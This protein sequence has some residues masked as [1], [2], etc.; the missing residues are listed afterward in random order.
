MDAFNHSIIQSIRFSHHKISFSLLF[1]RTFF[2]SNFFTTH[3]H[4]HTFTQN[5]L[6]LP[7]T[8]QRSGL[9]PTTVV[10]IFVCVLSALC[11]LHMSNTIS[12]VPGNYNFTKDVSYV[13]LTTQPK[14]LP[15]DYSTQLTS[16]FFI[17]IISQ[18]QT[19]TIL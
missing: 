2:L 1:F 19:T 16:P 9:I 13:I 10:I 15:I 7:D 12:K 11:C 14:L 4:T 8:Y 5:R 6:C 18:Q 3:T 17:S